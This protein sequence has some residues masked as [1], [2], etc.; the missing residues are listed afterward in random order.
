MDVDQV[1]AIGYLG[2]PNVGDEAL[3]L[4]IVEVLKPQNCVQVV[5]GRPEITMQ[6]VGNGISCIKGP[7][8]GRRLFAKEYFDLISVVKQSSGVLVIGGG[9]LQNVHSN[10]LLTLC[11]FFASAANIFNKRFVGVGVGYGPISSN[12]GGWLCKFVLARFSSLSLRDRVS[13]SQIESLGVVTE[14]RFFLGVDSAFALQ[15]KNGMGAGDA[16]GLCFRRWDKLKVNTLIDTVMKLS[17]S[18]REVVFLAFEQ[19]DVEFYQEIFGSN[20]YGNII[21]PS[22]VDAARELISGLS[23]VVSMRLHACIFAAIEGVPFVAISYDDKVKNVMS[24]IGLDKNIVDLNA[25]PSEILDVLKNSKTLASQDLVKLRNVA[26]NGIV[27][28]FNC[29]LYRS[30]FF[31]K[32]ESVIFLICL[33][34]KLILYPTLRYYIKRVFIGR[35]FFI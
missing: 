12:F 31:K 28:A 11:A 13:L 32:S 20:C 17:E 29:E 2:G 10:N 16:I 3:A 15:P 5:S 24:E 9:V 21:F 26:K 25:S 22:S 4:A 7:Y 8:P 1:I 14:G 33:Y 23:G 6:M 27:N 35:C 30:S 34:F 18:G 19:K